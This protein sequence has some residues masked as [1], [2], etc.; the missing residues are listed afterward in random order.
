M[1][2]KT[3]L[4]IDDSATI[5]RL[6]DTTLSPVGYAVVLASGAEEGLS[7]AAEV[8]P[9][10]IILDHQLPGTTG[11]E[12]CTRLL[13]DENLRNVPVITSSTMRKKAYMEYADCPNV[14]DMLPKP[15]TAELLVTT[16]ANAMDTASLVVDSQLQGTSVPEVMEALGDVALTGSLAKFS[17]RAVLDFL[18]NSHQD[19]VLEVEGQHSRVWIYLARGR[20]QAVTANGIDL[21]E[22]TAQLPETLQ[23]LAPV[24]RLTVGGGACTQIEGL[25]QLLD[26]KVLDPRLLQKLLRHQAAMLLLNC[27]TRPLL[28]FRF[29]ADQRAPALHQRLPLDISVVA[30]LVEGCLLADADAVP[31]YGD[32]HE[33]S[34]RAIRGQN[35]DRAGLSAQHQKVLSQLNEGVSLQQLAGQLQWDHEEARR[36]LY[37]LTLADLVEA[38]TVEM[39]RKVVVLET[40]PHVTQ[41]LREAADAPGCPLVVKVVRDRLSLQLILKRQH[42]DIVVLALDNDLGQQV[43]HELTQQ[44]L[45]VVCLGIVSQEGQAAPFSNRMDG[46]LK[47]PFGVNE[48]FRAIEHAWARRHEAACAGV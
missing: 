34:R 25:V 38:K 13:A 41:Q 33:F 31:V 40:D 32:Q 36:V 30:L 3:V 10:L 46:L 18:N 14:I 1:S 2:Q 23:D 21:N 26:N 5:R 24:L 12:V 7:R 8:Q 48:L 19:G 17:L 4:V 29:D 20:V 43:A 44:D 15:Y 39:G 9:D 27:F 22:L 47:R 35:L 16:I 42:P 6:V 11:V 45:D 28:A 37:A